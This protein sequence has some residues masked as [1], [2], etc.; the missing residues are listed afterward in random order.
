[1]KISNYTNLRHREV[2]D[3]E[4]TKA[5]LRPVF[6]NQEP[7]SMSPEDQGSQTQRERTLTFESIPTELRNEIYEMALTSTSATSNRILTPPQNLPFNERREFT[8]E[9]FKR[10]QRPEAVRP[11]GS[12]LL[13]VSRLVNQEATPILYGTNLLSVDA[14]QLRNVL[15]AIGASIKHI[16]HIEV[17]L[18]CGDNQN[19]VKRAINLLSGATALWRL[20]IAYNTYPGPRILAKNMARD[21]KPWVKRLIKARKTARYKETLST[22]DFADIV[23]FGMGNAEKRELF[24]TEYKETMMKSLD[25]VK[26][27]KNR[28][29]KS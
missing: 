13:R 22:E 10:D 1:M 18:R 14:E 19:D 12:Q 6:I 21:L 28:R 7:S 9:D 15:D 27:Q 3:A 17:V 8:W 20:M 5:T 25:Q 2:F 24:N 29:L 11:L 16:R 26:R 23:S 4:S